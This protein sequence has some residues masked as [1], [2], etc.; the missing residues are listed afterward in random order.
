MMEDED[1]PCCESVRWR[2]LCIVPR[3]LTRPQAD[4]GD[5]RTSSPLEVVVEGE[6]AIIIHSK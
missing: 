1:A 3:P 4:A 2:L 6:Q 5:L